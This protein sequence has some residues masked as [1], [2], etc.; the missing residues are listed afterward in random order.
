[1]CPYE[2]LTRIFQYFLGT[3]ECLSRIATPEL[4]DLF[5]GAER[6]LDRDLDAAGGVKLAGLSHDELSLPF[7]DD[8]VHE[9]D[10][11]IF[12]YAVR[13]RFRRSP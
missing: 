5:L 12:L 4:P 3:Q 8:G 13:G 10:P 9:P 7:G 11:D 6:V 2:I 1:M